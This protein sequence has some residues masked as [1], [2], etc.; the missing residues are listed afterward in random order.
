MNYLSTIR[1]GNKQVSLLDTFIY[2][3]V[4]PGGGASKAN[5]TS[6]TDKVGYTVGAATIESDFLILDWNEEYMEVTEM[7]TKLYSLH[8]RW[9]PRLIG[10]ERMMFLSGYMYAEM[11]R[12][13]KILDIVTLAHKGRNKAERIKA[14][15]PFLSKTYFM[16]TVAEAA[17]KSLHRWHETMKHGDDGADSL[18]YFYDVAIPP[19]LN[20]LMSHRA[21][22]R[23]WAREERLDQLDPRTKAEAKAIGRFY[24]RTRGP[25]SEFTDSFTDP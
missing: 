1:Y 9:R 24:E 13:G 15:I 17:Q 25:A 7:V 2:V 23:Q 12:R 14:F 4:D 10:V 11:Q 18:A 22:R 21:E 16:R 3:T 6:Q 5:A 19:T 20:D 8:R